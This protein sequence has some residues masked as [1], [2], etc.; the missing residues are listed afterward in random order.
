MW[1]SDVH[2]LTGLHPGRDARRPQREQLVTA[3]DGLVRNDGGRFLM[4]TRARNVAVLCFTVKRS[5]IMLRPMLKLGVLG[6]GRGS[7][8]Q[9]ILDAIAGGALDAQVVCVLADV[10][11]AFILDRA[12]RAGVPAFAL[13]CTPYKTKLDGEAERRAIATLR[14]HGADTIALAGFMR[15]IKPGLLQAFPGR[16]LNIHPSLLPAFPGLAAWEQ[17]V[18]YGAR[19]S[20]CTVHFVDA[21]MDTGPI[22]VQRAVPVQAGDTPSTLHARIQEQEHLAYP[23]AL[24]MLAAGRL[25][26]DGRRVRIAPPDP[27]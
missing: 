18:A 10:P 13:D 6:S 19:V 11:G 14:E 22:I 21:G 16:I 26:I 7:N 25:S 8:L 27:P 1:D 9:S 12:R 20:G 4:H 5:G 15:I 2:K 24:A 17:A 23:E 3:L